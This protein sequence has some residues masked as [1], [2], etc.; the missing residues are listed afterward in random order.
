MRCPCPLPNLRLGGTPPV[1]RR[2]PSPGRSEIAE[3]LEAFGGGS[4]A[5]HCWMAVYVQLTTRS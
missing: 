1:V 3:N 4:G 2:L 5:W